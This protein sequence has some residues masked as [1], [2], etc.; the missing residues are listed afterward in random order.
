MDQLFHERTVD[1]IEI[2]NEMFEGVPMPIVLDGHHRL[3]AHILLKRHHIMANYSGD[4][5]L[6]SY[7]SGSIQAYAQVK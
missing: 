3:L 7:L 1:P 2:D 6:L 4:P 5:E